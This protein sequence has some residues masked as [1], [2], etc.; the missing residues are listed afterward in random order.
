LDLTQDPSLFADVVPVKPV[1]PKAIC[2]CKTAHKESKCN[3]K[4]V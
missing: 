2:R 1:Y 3:L 4:C